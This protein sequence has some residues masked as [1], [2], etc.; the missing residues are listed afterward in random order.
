M[1]RD[2]TIRR[3][4][5]HHN[6]LVMVVPMAVRKVLNIKRGDYVYF[7]WPRGRKTVRFGKVKLRG[8]GNGKDSRHSS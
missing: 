8:S 6:S 5:K 7:S 2:E 3:V 1:V 4:H